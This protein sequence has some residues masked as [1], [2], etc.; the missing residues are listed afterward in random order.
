[1]ILEFCRE[2]G[3]GAAVVH[4]EQVI[5]SLPGRP[6]LAWTV[7]EAHC[8][9]YQTPQVRRALQQRRTGAATKLRKVQGCSKVPLASEWREWRGE[10]AEGHFFAPE[11]ELPIIRGW[12][13][14]FGKPVKV[15]LKDTTRPRALV[16]Q[17]RPRI[18]QVAGTCTVPGVPEK[19]EEI[20]S[21]CDRL[22]LEYRGEGLPGTALKALQ[23]LVKRNRERVYLDGEQKA[24]LLEQYG[25]R[26]AACG[27][28]SSQLEW[29]H[30]ARVSDSFGAQEFQP[31]CTA[32]HKDKTS[33]ESRSL[34]TDILGS[35]FELTVW[36]QYVESPRPPP[37]VY[38]V[39][40]L[41]EQL[42]ENFLIADVQRCRKRALELSAH[43]LPMFCVLDQIVERMEPELGDVC[44]VT[45]RY[46]NCVTQLGYTGPG[47]VHRI[48]AEHLLH[49]GVITWADVSHTLTATSRYPAGLLGGPLR[50]MEAAWEGSPLAKLAVN[51]LI[52]LLSVDETRSYKL[53]SSRRDCDA[54]AGALK[55]VF[56]YAD[57][58]SVY[59]FITS[60]SLLSNVSCRPL[61]DLA[62]CSEAVRVGQMLY[63]IRQS[64]AVPF[65]LKTDSCL[66]RPQKR[67]KVDLALRY[68]DLHELRDKY[69]PAESLQRLDEWCSI[70]PNT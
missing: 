43:D 69:E 20:Q 64:K 54:P 10:I 58:E 12:F 35:S 48:M 22:G 39:R 7:H 5:E 47:W 31:L 13:L 18:D 1:M 36:K 44:F 55:Q 61:H 52:G 45:A 21:W 68:C 8:W 15:L 26:C 4:N 9:F 11:E 63:C 32:C 46:K 16:Y 30:V 34:D 17:M 24:A 38:R 60:D 50:E 2:R 56:H 70:T 59:D 67:R 57:G 6:V 23:T 14:S 62:L 25:H 53:R 3:Y 65:E 42:E 19:W 66:F 49:H 40:A 51:S 28:A 37:L 33:L 27:A 41:P 29:D